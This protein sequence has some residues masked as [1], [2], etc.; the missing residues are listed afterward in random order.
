MSTIEYIYRII[1]I[2]AMAV[3]LVVA[4]AAQTINIPVY[5]NGVLSSSAGTDIQVVAT[6]HYLTECSAP[7]SGLGRC[8][9]HVHLSIANNQPTNLDFEPQESSMSMGDATVAPMDDKQVHILA[10]SMMRHHSGNVGDAELQ[11]ATTMRQTMFRRNTVYG[12]QS[13]AGELYFEIPKDQRKTFN[14]ATAH[15]T[16]LLQG[17]AYQLQF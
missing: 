2:T 12:G 15:L 11:D 7:A 1:G 17:A 5:V 10:D 6:F 3:L 13:V 4:A 16:V 14:P 9:I 8:A